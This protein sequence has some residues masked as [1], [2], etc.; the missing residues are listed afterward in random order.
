MESTAQQNNTS[1]PTSGLKTAVIILSIVVA[2]LAG[3]LLYI[4]A[5]KVPQQQQQIVEL[6]TEKDTLMDNLLTLRTQYD[7]LQTSND[8]LNAQLDVEKQKVDMMIEKLKKTDANNKAQIRQYEKELGTLR[9]IMRGYIRQ[10]D[11]LNTL[12][13]ALREET[14][15][16]KAEARESHEKYQSLVQTTDDLAKQVEKGSVIKARDISVVAINEKGKDQTRASRTD[17]LKACFTLVEN[18]I[19]AKGPRN[20]FIRVKGPDGILMTQSEAN[21]FQA[22]GEQLIYSAVREVDYQ[23]ADIEVCI[24]YGGNGETFTKGTYTVDI[25]SGGALIGHGEILLK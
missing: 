18:S 8:T 19:A 23:G 20:I 24:F 16:A 11:S 10:I 3:A 14:T 17:K 25:Y 1:R 22:N 6:R 21:V 2:I 5:H 7:D 4:A 15:T 9:D 12:N 13:I